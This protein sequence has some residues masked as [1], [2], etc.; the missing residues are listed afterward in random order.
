[1]ISGLSWEKCWGRERSDEDKQQEPNNEPERYV[2]VWLLFVC[3][4]VAS[5]SS[6]ILHLV[7]HHESHA[8][9]KREGRERL[10]MRMKDDRQRTNRRFAY[11]LFHSLPNKTSKA[12][13]RW[14]NSGFIAWLVCLERL[15]KYGTQVTGTSQHSIT[16]SLFWARGSCNRMWD[17]GMFQLLVSPFLV[18]I[19]QAPI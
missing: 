2:I 18:H 17:D 16:T 14:A 15:G 10:A 13:K 19:Q 6:V 8:S 11:H 1:M 5:V 12:I 4:C 9:K 7:P 3:L